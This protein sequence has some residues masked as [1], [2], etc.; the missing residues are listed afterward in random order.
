MGSA[1]QAK[2][3]AMFQDVRTFSEL[4][5]SP[6]GGVY[7]FSKKANMM[8]VHVPLTNQPVWCDGAVPSG[9]K[10]STPNDSTL[11]SYFASEHQAGFVSGVGGY[12]VG[13]VNGQ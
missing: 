8:F 1:N 10:C 2:Q 7:L 12:S 6:S 3:S 11:H 5:H 9:T 4:I 13:L